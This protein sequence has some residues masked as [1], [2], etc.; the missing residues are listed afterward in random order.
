MNTNT[1]NMK[2][3]RRSP[4]AQTASFLVP[5][6]KAQP[7]QKTQIL[8]VPGTTELISCSAA[9]SVATSTSLNLGLIPF[10]ATRY[11][12]TF[13]EARILKI[14]AEIRPVASTSTSGLSVFLIDENDSAVPNIAVARSHFGNAISNNGQAY[15]VSRGFEKR[16]SVP[17]GTVQMLEWSNRD[18]GDLKYLD[19][20]DV[21]TT[22]A[23][24]KC[25]T[26][27]ANFGTPA[28]AQP[29]FVVRYT[30]TI[31]LRGQK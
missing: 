4:Q 25:F 10:F 21:T 24:L 12:V 3:A 28:V 22:V 2:R 6:L 27:N 30:L 29:L 7:Y 19:S 15:S 5:N 20:T 16:Q 1:K 11:G 9:G 14:Y 17:S 13:D 31:E 8:R 26:D 23:Y 18:L